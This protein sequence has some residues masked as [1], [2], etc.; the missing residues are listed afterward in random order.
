MRAIY[1]LILALI[2]AIILLIPVSISTLQQQ[3][4]AK[5]ITPGNSTI[6][7]PPPTYKVKVKFDSIKV[8]ETHDPGI[9]TS[10]GD[11]EYDL[12]AFVQGV[13][14]GLTDRSYEG[15]S[16]GSGNPLPCGLGDVSH[17]ETVYFNPLAEVTVD[18]PE[19]LPLS[20]FTAGV[21]VDNCGRIS[22]TRSGIPP[23]VQIVG[24]L[25]QP[26]QTWVQS[27]QKYVRYVSN[28]VSNPTFT[29]GVNVNDRLGSIMNFYKPPDY[30]AGAHEEFANNVDYILR[31]TITVMPPPNLDQK[32]TV[33][34]TGNNFSLN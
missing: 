32:K 5:G 28:P 25:N 27:L 31:Y 24:I 16:G 17:G 20:I 15:I 2:A 4:Y 14:I 19:T 13:P 11:G 29:C 30:G 3:V 7:F 18:I 22:L 1:S 26:E 33:L 9:F 8:Q 10:Q 12:Y 23:P 6:T 21:E 34:G